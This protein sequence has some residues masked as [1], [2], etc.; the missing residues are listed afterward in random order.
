V[1]VQEKNF[2]SVKTIS[3]HSEIRA[4]DDV[5]KKKRWH[6]KEKGIMAKQKP[7]CMIN[8]MHTPVLNGG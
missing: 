7:F 4:K 6:E 2:T 1:F 3:F 5:K 8:W